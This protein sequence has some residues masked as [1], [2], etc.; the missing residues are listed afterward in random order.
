MAEAIGLVASV[1]SLLD[2]ALKLSNALHNLQFQVRNA[3]YLIQAL[4][5]ET[6]AIRTV[7]AHV[8]NTIQSTAAARLGGP[9]SSVLLGDLAIELGKGAAVLKELGTFID[10]L[11]KETS[12]LRRV[13][14]VHK[15]ERAAELI[16]ELKEVRSR[17]SELQLA[18]GNSSL[19]RIELILQDIQ[20]MQRCHYATTQS[21]GTCL[22]ETRDQLTIDR[23]TTFQNQSD[24]SAALEA[25]RN[26]TPTL[27]PEWVGTISNQLAT[28]I[29]TMRPGPAK[30]I[31][32]NI[33]PRQSHGQQ[34][35]QA[36][37]SPLQL[38]TLGFKLRLVQSQCLINCACRCHASVASYRLWNTLPKKLQMIM[39]SVFF[40]YSSCPVSRTT[41]DLHSCFKSR[42]TRLTVRYGFP[43]WSFKY[44]I[45]ILVEKLS[46]SSLTF[47]LALRRKIP[48]KAS[49]DNIVFQAAIGNLT[50]VKR[51]V[52]EN[53]AAILDVDYDGDSALSI[54]IE[55]FLPWELSLQ[56]CE[57]LL[58]A[59]ADPDQV[60]ERGLSF[61][62]IIA[63]LVLQNTI[64]LKLHYQVERLIQI[65]SCLEDL[66]F[67]FIHE[68]VVKRCP[69]D[70][71]PI[72]EAGKTDIM[73]QIHSEDRFGMTPLMYAV[74][75]GDAKSAEALI[76]A[77]ASV[78]KKGPY[79]RNLVDY[80]GLLSPNSCATILH[81][82][83]T[84]GANAIDAFPTGWS[85]LHTAAI[86]DNVTM[87]EKL[88]QEGAR[89]DCIGP[90]GNRPIHYAASDN[91]VNAIRLLYEKGAGINVLADNGLSPLGVAIRDNA[92]DAQSAL[93]ELGAD[94]LITG[95]WGTHFHLAAYWGNERTFTTLYCLKLKGLDVDAKDAKGLTATDI[96]EDRYDKT[97]ELTLA[98]YQLKDSIR[99]QSL[100]DCQ[101]EDEV[102]DPDEFFDAHDF[103]HDD[104]YC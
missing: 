11:K 19:T 33:S 72:L 38:P 50:A 103:L 54:C 56:I 47:T 6:E 64:P 86:H 71:A 100:E 52:F 82:L 4:E 80:A 76:E 65:S 32:T 44:A 92:T 16:K 39:G 99:L 77:G 58:Q 85:L 67:T 57:V 18:Y 53:P 89:P 10:S 68:I 22:L 42:L 43:L 69:I 9:G 46:T 88:L 84:A 34:G 23:N 36:I 101:G 60:N 66:D 91:S 17:I 79:G 15:R 3:P 70:L 24:I 78:H 40:E 90:R 63:N 95:D 21:L 74:A 7:L 31:N 35:S 49:R 12:T 51:I 102:E 2:L 28:T 25:L 1:A 83:L 87:I 96:Y 73:A 20:V 8:E 14:W 75:L 62:H 27:P 29:N 98:F 55:R 5:N 45:H 59:G 61:R 81:L 41:C 94:H 37:S 97:D 48:L 13:K 104:S 26:T 93:L 30:D